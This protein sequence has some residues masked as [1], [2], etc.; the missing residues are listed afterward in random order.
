VAVVS[1]LRGF[2]EVEELLVGDRRARGRQRRYELCGPLRIAA[3]DRLT[4][5]FFP[6]ALDD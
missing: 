1:V 5:A 6:V 4:P 3:E 2:D